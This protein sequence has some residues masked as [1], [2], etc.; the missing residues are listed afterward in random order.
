MINSVFLISTGMVVFFLVPFL[1]IIINPASLSQYPTADDSMSVVAQTAARSVAIFALVLVIIQFILN[2]GTI[3]GYQLLAISVLVL[4]SCFL[5]M[6]FI[7]EL[8]GDIRVLFFHLQLTA[9]RYSGLLLF[10]GLYF[11]LRSTDI[12]NIIS[13]FFGVFVSI[14][15]LAWIIHELHYLLIKQPEEWEREDMDKIEY[16]GKCGQHLRAKIACD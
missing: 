9:L 16:L 1:Q 10:L 4:C 8:I 14:A 3:D 11:L 5:M 15:W 7:M 2:N 13:A 6:A 12:P